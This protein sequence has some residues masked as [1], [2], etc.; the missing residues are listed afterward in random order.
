M[1]E[2]GINLAALWVPVMAETSKIADQMKKAG[3]EGRRAFM[4]G[5]GDLGLND[6]GNNITKGL[7]QGFKE[8]L[9]GLHSIMKEGI[10]AGLTAAFVTKGLEVVGEAMSKMVETV[11][12]GVTESVKAIL[13]VGEA[14]EQVNRQIETTSSASGAALEQLN[15]SA[16]N[17]VKNLDVPMQKVG[18]TIGTLSTRLKMDAGPALEEL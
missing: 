15:R 3:E 6:V 9:P 8:G 11:E 2:D 18:A 17:V 14:W 16:D 5:F 13:E 7:G 10:V 4:S 1:S 12:E